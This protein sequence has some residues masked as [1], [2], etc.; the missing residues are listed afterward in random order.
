[1]KL[2][3][4]IPAEDVEIVLN[5]EDIDPGAVDIFGCLLHPVLSAVSISNCTMPEW[6]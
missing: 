1:M 3:L 2:W 6:E 5:T 4:P